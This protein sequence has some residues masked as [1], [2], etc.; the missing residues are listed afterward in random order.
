MTLSFIEIPFYGDVV[1]SGSAV[2]QR[3]LRGINIKTLI[4]ISGR[5]LHRN[6]PQF[7]EQIIY[8]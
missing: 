4:I 8:E 5:Y 3:T 2:R 6:R 1:L 7:S